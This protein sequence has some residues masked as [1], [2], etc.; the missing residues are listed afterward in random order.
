MKLNKIYTK[1][2]DPIEELYS[3]EEISK[4]DIAP[5]SEQFLKFIREVSGSSIV[6]TFTIGE[7][8]K[9]VEQRFASP[10]D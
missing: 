5:P 4:D 2:K 3:V 10:K 6:N 7:F 1:A 8:T 9:Q